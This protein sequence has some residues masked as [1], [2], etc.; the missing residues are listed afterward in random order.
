MQKKTL[1]WLRKLVW[2]PKLNFVD[3]ELKQIKKENLYRK[4]RYGTT[5][6][7]FIK[8]NGKNLINLCSNDYLGIPKTEIDVKQMQSSSRLVSGNDEL[9]KN[10][11]K[12]LAMHK[13]E[14]ASLV[15]PTGYMA[16]LGVI[17]AIAKKEIWS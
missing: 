1:R 6:K 12:K 14:G 7:A 8:I 16:N 9:Y 5:D 3:S 15:Y 10:L 13:S 11:E 17:P 2:K 4:L